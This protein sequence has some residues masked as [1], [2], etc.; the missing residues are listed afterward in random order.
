MTAVATLLPPPEEASEE[1]E[2]DSGTPRINVV[3]A[4]AAADSAAGL[5]AAKN[6]TGWKVWKFMQLSV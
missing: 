2:A 4:V 5:G 3:V 1:A 6:P